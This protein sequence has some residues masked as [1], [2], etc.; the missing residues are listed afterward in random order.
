MTCSTHWARAAHVAGFDGAC[1]ND[2]TGERHG[3]FVYHDDAS[4]IPKSVPPAPLSA[5]S[6]DGSKLIHA[7]RVYMP[8]RRPPPLDKSKRNTLRFDGDSGRWVLTSG[9]ERVATYQTDELRFSVVYRAR[10]FTDEAE[11]ARFAAQKRGTGPD[12][13]GDMVRR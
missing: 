3:D 4:G 6:V 8:D 1:R 10:C 2:T 12:D 11:R 13:N 5:S 7:A 9:G